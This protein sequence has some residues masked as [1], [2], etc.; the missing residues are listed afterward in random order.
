MQHQL[1]GVGTGVG[2]EEKDYESGKKKLHRQ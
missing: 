2:G 1:Y